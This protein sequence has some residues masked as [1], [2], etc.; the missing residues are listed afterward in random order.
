MGQLIFALVLSLALVGG[1]IYFWN[2]I[3]PLMPPWLS[4]IVFILAAI[5]VIGYP[6]YSLARWSDRRFQ[7][8][9]KTERG[10]AAMRRDNNA[11]YDEED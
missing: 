7:R 10:Q 6:I 5:A 3:W 8:Y 11:A 2:D 9:A 1:L 4:M